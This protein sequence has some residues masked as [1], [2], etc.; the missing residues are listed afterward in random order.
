MRRNARF[1]SLLRLLLCLKGI[2]H[3]EPNGGGDFRDTLL[4]LVETVFGVLDASM[5]LVFC[6]E[7]SQSAFSTSEKTLDL[8]SEDCNG[9]ISPARNN[10]LHVRDKGFYDTF[11]SSLEGIGMFDSFETAC[12]VTNLAFGLLNHEMHFPGKEG[13]PLN[14]TIP[15]KD[16]TLDSFESKVVRNPDA[17]HLVLTI[18]V[19]LLETESYLPLAE[20]SLN[21][22]LELCALDKAP[23]ILSQISGS[24]LCQSLTNANGFVTIFDN[25][26]HPLY[27]RFVVLLQRIASFKMSHMDFINVLRCIAGPVLCADMMSEHGSNNNVNSKRLRLPTLTSS[28]G[29]RGDQ[30]SFQEKELEN[31]LCIR[32]S[33]LASIAERGDRVARCFVG[34]DSLNTIAFY[35]HTV[36]I[37]DKLYSLAEKG[38]TKFIEIERIDASARFLPSSIGSGNNASSSSNL[39]KTW[40]PIANSGFSYSAWIRLPKAVEGSAFIFDL[41]TSPQHGERNGNSGKEKEF[42]SVWYDFQNQVFNVLSS[43]SPKPVSFLPSPLGPGVWHHILLTYQPQSKRPV[44]SSRKSVVGLCIDGRALETDIK[45]DSVTLPPTS[46]L[47]IGVPNPLLASCGTIHG[48]L[49]LWELGSTLLLSTI[50]GPSDALSI[51]AARPDFQG[52]FWGERPQRLSLSATATSMFSMLA[53]CGE[54]GGVTEALKRRSLPEVA[55]A[56]HIMRD[57]IFNGTN[58][59]GADSVLLSAMGLFCSLSPEYIISAFHPSSS[60]LSMQDGSAS[61]SKRHFSR[62]LVNVAKI[63]SNWMRYEACKSPENSIVMATQRVKSP[64]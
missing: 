10:R 49:P 38:R 9:S 41:S 59:G 6:K 8:L 22:L 64:K 27:S 63:N 53:E 61:N 14:P 32:L 44:I 4:R 12:L 48:E 1:E 26:D 25:I 19:L 11:M 40:P 15:H 33:T 47:F 5:G 36:E 58:A 54:D 21:Q 16:S 57:K 30:K 46:R 3:L 23:S 55:A 50:L 17:T 29:S 60:T 51:F 62:R 43:I 31:N 2:Q 37:E 24:G 7:K 20:W 39:E 52:Q 56:S 13:T 28:V 34:G 42:I 35:M 18:A 45:I